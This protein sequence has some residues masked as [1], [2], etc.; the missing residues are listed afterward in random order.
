MTK[1]QRLA[2]LEEKLSQWPVTEATLE[3]IANEWERDVEG[4]IDEAR[5]NDDCDRDGMD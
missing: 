2:F 1:Q 3:D 4:S 5:W